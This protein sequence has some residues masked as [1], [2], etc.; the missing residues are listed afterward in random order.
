MT[1]FL[2]VV[3]GLAGVVTGLLVVLK[4]PSTALLLIEDLRRLMNG[5][6]EW[7]RPRP[8]RSVRP[9]RPS[10]SRGLLR[11]AERRLP[12]ALSSAEKERWT[13]EM[14]ADVAS[15]PRRKRLRVA[16]NAWRKGAAGIPTGPENTP[17]S[18]R[19]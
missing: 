7:R 13:Q 11:L 16:F 15:L 9:S 17:R 14:R 5:A 8:Q 1:V 10:L 4:L 2:S 18:A 12:D 3:V 19:D 6:E